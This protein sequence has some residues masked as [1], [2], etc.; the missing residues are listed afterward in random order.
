MFPSNAPCAN[1]VFSRT[2][3]RLKTDNTRE[4]WQ[5]TCERITQGIAELGKL[6]GAEKQLLY[7]NALALK[8]LPSGRWLWVGGTDWVKVPKNF[9]G[10]YNCSSSNL[11]TLKAFELMMNLTMQG[12]GTGAV[13]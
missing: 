11:D 9:Y 8:S 7:N 5:D 10:A 13:I 4:N 6:T 12:C 1:P 2:Y 3:S